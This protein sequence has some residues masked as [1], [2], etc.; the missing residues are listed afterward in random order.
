MQAVP[1]EREY[2]TISI[3]RQVFY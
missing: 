2:Q 1:M 3:F